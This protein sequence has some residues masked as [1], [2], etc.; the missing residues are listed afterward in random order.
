MI[1]FQAHSEMCD[2]GDLEEAG[3]LACPEAEWAAVQ[4]RKADRGHMSASLK[5]KPW[6]TGCGRGW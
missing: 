4:P 3:S 6:R 2:G 1:G 5:C